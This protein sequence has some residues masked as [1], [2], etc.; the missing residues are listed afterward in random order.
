RVVDPPELGIVM[1]D[2]A[3]GQ[4]PYALH[5]DIVDDGREDLLARLV[6]VSD[7]DPDELAAPVLHALV[8]QPDR[9]GLA[10]ALELVHEHRR[11]EV[12]DVQGQ[13]RVERHAQQ[14]GGRSE[15]QYMYR[16]NA[17]G[18]WTTIRPRL[19]VSTP[20]RC[21]VARNRLAASR[22]VP[23]SWARSAWV[24]RTI[25]SLPGS[26]GT[27]AMRVPV[28]TSSMSTPATRLETF[29]KDWREIRAFVSR[30]R[31]ASAPNS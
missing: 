19:V 22:D 2:V 10:T 16:C 8:A 23:A 30:S 1:L 17:G 26:P 12:Q 13:G 7:R 14:S 6:A 31:S 29:W 21:S 24:E 20:A 28:S 3:R 15:T 25:T 27:A 18:S 11:V 4:L 9:G 5:L